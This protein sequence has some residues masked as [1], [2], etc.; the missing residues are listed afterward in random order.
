LVSE[1]A[2]SLDPQAVAAIKKM[3]R[4]E[5]MHRIQVARTVYDQKFHGREYWNRFG[6]G[7]ASR[8]AREREFY[9]TLQ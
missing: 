2:P 4:E 5:F 7:L 8:Y 6:T 1:A 9:G 3:P